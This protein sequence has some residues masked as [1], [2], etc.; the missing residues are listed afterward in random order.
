LDFFR[1]I[2]EKKNPRPPKSRFLVI[3]PKLENLVISGRKIGS[4]HKPI[5]L[6]NFRKTI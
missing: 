4:P 3:S 1:E 6:E 5:F 2:P